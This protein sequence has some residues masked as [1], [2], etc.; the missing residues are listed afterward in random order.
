M[1]YKCYI[2]IILQL[3]SLFNSIMLLCIIVRYI[4][5]SSQFWHT[6][7][8]LDTLSLSDEHFPKELDCND[9]GI[10]EEDN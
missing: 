6:A 7:G 1:L 4:H 5:V 10:K 8:K 9:Y 3:V 2:V